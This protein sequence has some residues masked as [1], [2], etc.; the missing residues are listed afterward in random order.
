LGSSAGNRPNGR[1]FTSENNFA[2]KAKRNKYSLD[3][4]STLCQDKVEKEKIAQM[5]AGLQAKIILPQ[6]KR[7]KYSFD[8][9]FLLCQDKVDRRKRKLCS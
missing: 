4:C 2:P 1:R 9:L 7:N 8:F 6:A 3:L 5:V